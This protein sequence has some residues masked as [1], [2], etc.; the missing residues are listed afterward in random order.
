MKKEEIENLKHDWLFEDDESYSDQYCF[1][2][3]RTTFEICDEKIDSHEQF[4]DDRVNRML[5][6]MNNSYAVFLEKLIEEA[7]LNDPMVYSILNNQ[8]SNIAKL[9]KAACAV[10]D[11]GIVE[12]KKII[13]DHT[14]DCSKDKI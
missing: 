6:Y 5:N 10:I 13:N 7:G 11:N 14:V 8:Q 12:I 1:Y 9:A 3:L 2:C 4:C